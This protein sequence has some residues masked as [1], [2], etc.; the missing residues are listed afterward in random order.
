MMFYGGCC[1]PK[2]VLGDDLDKFLDR[3][4]GFDTLTDEL[5]ISERELENLLE[6]GVFKKDKVTITINHKL[7]KKAGLERYYNKESARTD[8]KKDFKKAAGSNFSSSFDIISFDNN[9]MIVTV[10]PK[11]GLLYLENVLK[12]E[13]DEAYNILNEGE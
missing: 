4:G 7:Y 8:M 2:L 12:L 13:F 10:D 1:M 6:E 11:E 5:D 9:K 3:F